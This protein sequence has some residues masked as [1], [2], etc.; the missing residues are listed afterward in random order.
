MNDAQK[1]LMAQI[2]SGEKSPSDRWPHRLTPCS[3]VKRHGSWYEPAARPSGLPIGKPNRCFVNAFMLALE[4]STLT[5]CEGYALASPDSAKALHAWVTTGD[6]N[7]I[8]PTWHDPGVAYAGVPFQTQFLNLTHL[9][10]GQLISVLDDY[11]NN[12]PLLGELGDRPAEW[13]ACEGSGTRPL[14]RGAVIDLKSSIPLFQQVDAL[15]QLTYMREHCEQWLAHFDQLLQVTRARTPIRFAAARGDDPYCLNRD[16]NEKIDARSRERLLEQSIWRQWR[17]SGTT[18]GTEDWPLPQICRRVQTYQM[19]LQN[20]RRDAGWGKVD[21]VGVSPDHLPMVGELKRESS[22][23]GKGSAE[24]PLR[25]LSEA[26]CYGLAV[27]KAWAEGDLRREWA[28]RVTGAGPLDSLPQALD[29]VGLVCAAPDGYW[30]TRLATAAILTAGRVPPTAWPAFHRLVDRCANA[31]FD[32]HF[33]GFT[34]DDTAPG[35]PTIGRFRL[36]DLPVSDP[37]GTTQQLRVLTCRGGQ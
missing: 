16:P 20:S 34:V 5:Y 13:F 2:T 22:A 29:R 9:K 1:I 21:F 26:V 19:P 32:S 24:T 37:K 6:G 23:D 14:R 31:G 10:N 3:F 33:V 35:Q 4:D 28:T 30:Q 18:N 36:V 11:V 15:N 17:G 25:M 27:Q 7:V 8:D 12:W